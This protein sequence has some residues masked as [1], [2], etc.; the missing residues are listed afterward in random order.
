MLSASSLLQALQKTAAI[1]WRTPLARRVPLFDLVTNLPPKFL[2]TSGKPNRFNLS[3]TECIYFSDN[4]RTAQA[5]Y[6]RPLIGTGGERQ[7]VATFWAEVAL[8]RL[9]DLRNVQIR[10]ELALSEEELFAG[11]RFALQPTATQV[12]GEA[13]NGGAGLSAI[14]FPSDAA[15]AEQFEGTNLVIFRNQ[16]K[17]PDFVKTFGP[18]NELMEVWP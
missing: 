1:P 16:V 2:W 5:E 11:W 9:L 12:L 13:I 6:S 17:V 4:E 15:R 3:G 18:E 7:P 8:E 14:C 10:K